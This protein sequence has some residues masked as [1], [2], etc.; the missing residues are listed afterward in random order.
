MKSINERAATVVYGTPAPLPEFV[1][2]GCALWQMDSHFSSHGMAY[3]PLLC[4]DGREVQIYPSKVWPMHTPAWRCAPGVEDVAGS[5]RLKV[6]CPWP[7]ARLSN[8]GGM[9]GFV[10]SKF[11]GGVYDFIVNNVIFDYVLWR[12]LGEPSVDTSGVRWEP[13]DYTNNATARLKL[14]EDARDRFSVDQWSRIAR[15]ATVPGDFLDPKMLE[16]VAE[17]YHEL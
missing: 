3:N 2:V 13:L 9:S 6:T 14:L 11:E 1:L 7:R 12:V 15:S 4:K 5:P 16:A 8:V 10:T 17:L